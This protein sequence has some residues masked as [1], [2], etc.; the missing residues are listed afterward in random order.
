MPRTSVL[1]V[2]PTLGTRPEWLRLSVDSIFESARNADVNITVRIV[3]P[4]RVDLGSLSMTPGVDHVRSD[5]P[6]LSAAV[7]DGWAKPHDAGYVAWLGDDDV[8]SPMS[9]ALSISRLAKSP[10]ASACYGD[11]RSIDENGDTLWMMRPGDWAPH[12]M[13]VGKNLVPQPGSL[14]RWPALLRTGVLDESLKA[15]MDQDLFARLSRVGRLRYAGGEV[16]AFRI[17]SS[18]ITSVGSGSDEG[19][20]VRATYA[21]RIAPFLRPATK[22]TDRIIFGLM[23]RLRFSETPLNSQGTPYTKNGVERSY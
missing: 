22:I 20:R 10:S 11:V 1:F 17:H 4:S 9:L 3:T 12:Y 18:S 7:N 19:Q 23:R 13:S 21:P 15:A 8:L 2:V 16:A 14:F 6:G 5:R